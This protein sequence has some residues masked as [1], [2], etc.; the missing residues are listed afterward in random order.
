[1]KGRT[2]ASTQMAL[3]E[4]NRSLPCSEASPDSIKRKWQSW[5]KDTITINGTI[6]Y[7]SQR[8]IG[9]S[10]TIFFSYLD[11]DLNLFLLQRSHIS[12]SKYCAVQ[13]TWR[14][15]A[16][17]CIL[18]RWVRLQRPVVEGSREAVYLQE[19]RTGISDG[20]ARIPSASPGILGRRSSAGLACPASVASTSKD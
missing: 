18:F 12:E 20:I 3:I 14:T 13:I 1:M 7:Q 9:A 17:T 6:C 2:K 16:A 8:E 15:W 10:W 19:C 5:R 11:V 4:H